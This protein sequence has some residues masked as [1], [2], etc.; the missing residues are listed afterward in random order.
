M[1]SMMRRAI[2]TKI[3]AGNMKKVRKFLRDN[4]S[5]G[6]RVGEYLT[7]DGAKMIILYLHERHEY[8]WVVANLTHPD[9]LAK[10]KA[11]VIPGI[12]NFRYTKNRSRYTG[13]YSKSITRSMVY[14]K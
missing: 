1:V 6:A 13:R 2:P 10:L 7:S 14:V 9:E 3:P 5:K 8:E 4:L 11:F 12:R